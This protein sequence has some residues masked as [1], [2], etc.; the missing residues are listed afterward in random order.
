M[1]WLDGYLRYTRYQESPEVFH[2]WIG[3]SILSAA[4]DRRVWLERRGFGV[5]WYKIY[6]GQLM[7]VLIGTSGIKKTTAL[8]IGLKFLKHI[9]IPIIR[10]K[11]SAEAFLNDLKNDPH[12]VVYA[13]ELSVFL[14]KQTY[15]EP[16]IDILLE[17]ADA[18]DIFRFKTLKGGEV[19][20]NEPCVTLIG[21]TTPTGLG[22]SL[23]A[24]SHSSGFL[25]R[26]IIVYANKTDRFNP[27]TDVEDTDI[28]AVE[29][30]EMQ[31]LEAKLK[32]RLAEIA[33]M[34][35]PFRF[36]ADGRKWFDEFYLRWVNSPMGREEGYPQRRP[37]HLLRTAMVLQLS[38]SDDKILSEKVLVKAH[39]YLLE[40]ED[41]IESATMYIGGAS[42]KEKDKVLAVLRKAGGEMT[43]SQLL[44]KV[45]MYF[46]DT[47]HAQR[48]IMLLQNGGFINIDMSSG[49]TIIRI[50]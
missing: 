14:S 44:H 7:C 43:L 20:V 22:D 27:L 12:A 33:K 48:T 2:K 15:A 32:N 1:N 40:I 28:T 41:K 5:T 37:D 30:A 8:D 13:P 19:I 42:I 9:N 45:A 11:S 50:V 23:P 39:E 34:A 49:R 18:K 6:P 29:V 4:L 47:E 17:L 35:G 16:I 3:I 21:A 10:G 36:G 46:N 26:L 24:K 25:G 31:Q 38:E